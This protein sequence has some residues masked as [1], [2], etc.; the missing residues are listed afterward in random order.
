[1]MIHT[2]MAPA[3]MASFVDINRRSTDSKKNML[4]KRMK[5]VTIRTRSLGQSVTPV[6]H[7]YV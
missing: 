7:M 2:M 5:M 3:P 1:M 4:N 6:C